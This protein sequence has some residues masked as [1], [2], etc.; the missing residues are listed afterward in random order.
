MKNYKI[1]NR[2]QKFAEWN[3]Y[4]SKIRTVQFRLQKRERKQYQTLAE[5]SDKKQQVLKEIT[6]LG[7]LDPKIAIYSLNF[8]YQC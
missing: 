6:S 3:N 7:M 1:I 8:Q 5:V 4:D 2:Y